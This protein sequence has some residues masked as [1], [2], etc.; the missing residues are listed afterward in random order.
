[1]KTL[2]FFAIAL[3]ASAVAAQTCEINMSIT[4]AHKGAVK[5]KN[6]ATYSDITPAEAQDIMTRSLSVVDVASKA[7]DKRGDYT[8]TFDGSN[9]CGITAAPIVVDGL[10]HKDAAKVWRQSFK[11]AEGTIQKSEAHVAAGGKG[12]WGKK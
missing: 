11:A 3:F 12:P 2:L 4:T 8:V 6:T 1:M 10:T 7:Q 9:T 5:L